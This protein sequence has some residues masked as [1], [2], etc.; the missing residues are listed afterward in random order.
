MLLRTDFTESPPIPIEAITAIIEYL[1]SNPATSYIFIACFSQ[2]RDL[3][4]QWRA[5]SPGSTFSLAFDQPALLALAQSRGWRLEQCVYDPLEHQHII[6]GVLV[7]F[8]AAYNQ[9]AFD[10][11]DP[12]PISRAQRYSLSS[13]LPVAPLL[14]HQSFSEEKEWRLISPIVSE[15][16]HFRAGRHSIVPYVDF[17]LPKVEDQLWIPET[18]VGPTMYPDL[19]RRSLI[20][21]FTTY[22]VA[23]RSISMSSTPFREWS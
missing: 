2:Q 13:L 15:G 4:S 12:D 9:G 19:D 20:E 22:K 23:W 8:F 18:V 5:G 17:P 10:P 1:D 6:R 21:C 7:E 16:M 14:K 3:L 11:A